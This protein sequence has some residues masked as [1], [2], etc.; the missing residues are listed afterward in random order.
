MV[1]NPEILEQ[2]IRL[3]GGNTEPMLLPKLGRGGERESVRVCVHVVNYCT[4]L[5]RVRYCID[6]VTGMILLVLTFDSFVPELV[7]LS[8]YVLCCTC[9]SNAIMEI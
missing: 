9:V 6:P 7:M 3:F 8:L 2:K 1:T 4:E 5:C